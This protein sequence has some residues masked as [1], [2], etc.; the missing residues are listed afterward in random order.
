MLKENYPNWPMRSG[1]LIWFT[2]NQYHHIVAPDELATIANL[3]LLYQDK[4][5]Q[6]YFVQA[7]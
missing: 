5:G 6:I 2:P 1:Y 7:K 4:T 3:T